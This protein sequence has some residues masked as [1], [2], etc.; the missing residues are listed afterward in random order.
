MQRGQGGEVGADPADRSRRRQIVLAGGADGLTAP[1][2]GRSV[3]RS[4]VSSAVSSSA[5]GSGSSRIRSASTISSAWCRAWPRRPALPRYPSPG[6]SSPGEPQRQ[7]VDLLR[8]LLPQVREE[9]VRILDLG[10][11]GGQPPGPVLL[12]HQAVAVHAR[13]LARTAGHLQTTCPAG[14]RFVRYRAGRIG[15]ELADSGAWRGTGGS[16]CPGRAAGPG[17]TSPHRTAAHPQACVDGAW[18]QSC[19]PGGGSPDVVS[20]CVEVLARPQRAVPGLSWYLLFKSDIL[21]RSSW[22]RAR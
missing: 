3:S 20:V 9:A 18:P 7:A 2:P 15:G 8:C 22:K 1:G 21:V 6:W 12:G 5:P 11:P 14:I 16:G 13:L 19:P 4:A 17:A 10:V